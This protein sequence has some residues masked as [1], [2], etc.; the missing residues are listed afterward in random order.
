MTRAVPRILLAPLL[1]DHSAFQVETAAMSSLEE[2]QL[3]LEIP[4]GRLLEHTRRR[5]HVQVALAGSRPGPHLITEREGE[6]ID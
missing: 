5:V 1:T 4:L 3:W 6:M 2:P